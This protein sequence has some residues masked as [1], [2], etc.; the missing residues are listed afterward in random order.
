MAH[1]SGVDP[2]R[3][4]GPEMN[5]IKRFD[6]ALNGFRCGENPIRDGNKR[7][8]IEQLVAQCNG[9]FFAPKDA[10]GFSPQDSRRYDYVVIVG[11]HLV[12]PD[13]RRGRM[14]QQRAERHGTIEI[15]DSHRSLTRRSSIEDSVRNS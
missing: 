8:R 5:Y 7:Q 14:A 13:S 12:D 1:N 11:R 3:N 6:V 2:G 4:D 10:G 9:E 15:I